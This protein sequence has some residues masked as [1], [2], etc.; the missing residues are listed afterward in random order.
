MIREFD[1]KKSLADEVLIAVEYKR[2]KKYVTKI[3]G[4]KSFELKILNSRIITNPVLL[5]EV[6]EFSKLL[7]GMRVHILPVRQSL[8]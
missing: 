6:W 8:L 4:I 5:L 2:L 7:N 1:R 3:F